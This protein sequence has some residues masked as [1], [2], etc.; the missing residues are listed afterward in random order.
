M[1]L[2]FFWLLLP[3]LIAA[4]VPAENMEAIAKTVSVTALALA[5]GGA[6][7]FRSPSKFTPAIR[8]RLEKSL[9]ASIREDEILREAAIAARA[10][11]AAGAKP[12]MWEIRELRSRISRLDPERGEA[13]IRKLFDRY[14]IEGADAAF[15]RKLLLIGAS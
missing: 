15:M 5:V 7:L 2:G 10:A 14:G 13:E 1:K 12:S 11:P 9:L 4:P 8:D 6:L 3:S